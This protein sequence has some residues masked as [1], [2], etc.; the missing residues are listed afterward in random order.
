MHKNYPDTSVSDVPSLVFSL[1][2]T[3]QY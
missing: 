2:S 3:V 1:G